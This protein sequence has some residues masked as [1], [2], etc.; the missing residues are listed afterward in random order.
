ME[1]SAVTAYDL[2]A[3]SVFADAPGGTDQSATGT[4]DGDDLSNE[5]EWAL[6]TDPFVMGIDIYASWATALFADTWRL[7]GDGLTET[8]EGWIC[9]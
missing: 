7:N 9:R 8:S 2:W 1:R 5:Q 4:P 6:A 3:S